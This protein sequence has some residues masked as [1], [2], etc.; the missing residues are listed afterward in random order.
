MGK[1]TSTR[2][3]SRYPHASII[4]RGIKFTRFHKYIRV[5]VV[6]RDFQDKTTWWNIAGLFTNR[7]VNTDTQVVV[8]RMNG[9]SASDNTWRTKT[10]MLIETTCTSRHHVILVVIVI[11]IGYFFTYLQEN[12]DNLFLNFI[13]NSWISR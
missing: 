11:I 3:V 8:F 13:F 4:R 2:L 10:L 1:L 6:C 7:K 12:T 9:Y 5:T